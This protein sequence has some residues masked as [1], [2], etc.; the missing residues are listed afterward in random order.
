MIPQTW[1]G[2]EVLVMLLVGIAIIFGFVILFAVSAVFLRIKNYR[3]AARWDRLEA[4]W[5]PLIMEVLY[6]EDPPE[7]LWE[8]V[9]TADERYFI[10]F[11]V[12]YS[13]RLA[14]HERERL[15]TLARPYLPMVEAD[16][17]RRAPERR[18]RAVQTLGELGMPHYAELL[19]AA[20]DDRSALVAMAAARGLAR[21]EHPQYAGAVMK[22]LH[23]FSHWRPPFL[24]AMLA[25]MGSEAAPAIRATLADPERDSSVRT[26]AALALGQLH[27]ARSAEVAAEVIG[28]DDDREVVA[29]CLRLLG[30]VGRPEDLQLVRRQL[31][32]DDAI[33]R[34]AAAGALGHLGSRVDVEPL[35]RI[36]TTD[37]SRWVAIAAARSV[38]ELGG[39]KLLRDLAAS[40]HRRAS[41]ALQV[42]S[43]AGI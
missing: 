16:V 23:R 7:R 9:E 32:S 19:T 41:L 21:R 24:A 31:R 43:E 4:M 15:Q 6:G 28:R 34:G 26:V 3:K 37:E 38:R 13:R 2:G 8:V 40:T 18:A 11:L 12:R 14:G 25:G 35:Q 17:R 33:V 1:M 30:R 27:D 39:M 29:A 10:N 5:E 22:H 36:A 20:L 42:L